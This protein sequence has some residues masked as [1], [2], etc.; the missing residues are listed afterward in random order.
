M[1]DLAQAPPS[2]ISICSSSIPQTGSSS[3]IHKASAVPKRVVA[4]ATGDHLAVVQR[5]IDPDEPPD[6]E[7]VYSLIVESAQEPPPAGNVGIIYVLAVDRDDGQ[8]RAQTTA[9]P[10]D[11]Y[12]FSFDVPAGN[13]Y[14]VAG[15]DTSEALTIGAEGDYYGQW[16]ALE[17]LACI[18]V[19]EVPEVPEPAGSVDAQQ[20]LSVVLGLQL[21]SGPEIIRPWPQEP[22]PTLPIWQR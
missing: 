19:S 16:S 11:G 12:Q 2:Q 7:A 15:S 1:P 13:Y 20:P 22:A 17:Q 6:G 5:Y 10:A 8:V 21:G 14:L 9:E 18:A 4:P 3:T